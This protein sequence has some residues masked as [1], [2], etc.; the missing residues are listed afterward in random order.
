VTDFS[1]DSTLIR[2]P[3]AAVPLRAFRRLMQLLPLT[4]FRAKRATAMVLGYRKWDELLEAVADAPRPE[5]DER[6]DAA[7]L[8][9]RRKSQAQRL[10]TL[11]LDL[12]GVSPLELLA[13]WQP[14]ASLPHGPL[15]VGP[16][17]AEYSGSKEEDFFRTT[18]VRL[19]EN[20]SL[21]VEPF[22]AA[23]LEGLYASRDLDWVEFVAQIGS[24]LVD[25]KRPGPKALGRR[26][27][28]AAN[29][30]GEPRAVGN[31]ALS[32]QLGD[33]GPQNAKRAA[34]LL[35]QLADAD[36]IARAMKALAQS[37]LGSVYAHGEGRNI[38]ALHALTLWESAA[39]AGDTYAAF[40]AG[41]Y[42]ERGKG[43]V[44]TDTGK[45]AF[46]YR[47]GVDVGDVHCSTN[48]AA[49]LIRDD[50]LSTHPG[51]ADELIRYS[52]EA[53]DDHARMMMGLLRMKDKV[54]AQTMAGIKLSLMFGVQPSTIVKNIPAEF[55]ETR[56]GSPRQR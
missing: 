42:H 20:E 4:E 18:V 41:V 11:G 54:P 47:L 30:R 40:N 21:S 44:A 17:A 5:V 43:G 27:L 32:L 46:F 53:G 29:L 2:F 14:S 48:L 23:L 39:L 12:N 56:P 50:S 26:L 9:L 51:E 1:S 7:K 38:D 22:E 15:R 8:A 55:L 34:D 45:A 31:L 16:T 36:W 28:E 10:V 49:L 25:G 3:S 35:E 33:G 13:R 24:S 6:C 19:L 37:R 52:A